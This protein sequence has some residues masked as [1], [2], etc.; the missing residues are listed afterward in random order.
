VRP[1]GPDEHSMQ[2]AAVNHRVRIAEPRAKG[3]AQIDMGDLFGSQRVHQPELIDIDGHAA[4]RFADPEIVEGMER[5]R[6]ELNAGADFAE[7]GGL[8]E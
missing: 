8:F 7:R 5:V 2:I 3:V 4:R 6:P 1:T